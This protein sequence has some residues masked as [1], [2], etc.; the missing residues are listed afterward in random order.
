V[1]FSGDLRHITIAWGGL[2]RKILK[3]WG[4]IFCANFLVKV[5]AGG[6][7]FAGSAIPPCVGS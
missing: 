6:L 4:E 3:F 1:N 2:S 7:P 5:V